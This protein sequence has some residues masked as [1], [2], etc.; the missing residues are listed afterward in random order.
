MKITDKKCFFVSFVVL[1]VVS[2]VI[3]MTVNNTDAYYDSD[4]Y[5]ELGQSMHYSVRWLG[6]GFRGYLLPFFFSVCYEFGMYCHSEFL[7]YRIFSSLVFAL[8][9]SCLFRYV[10]RM[11]E[12]KVSDKR[13]VTAGG[14]CGICLFLFFRG[15]L[16]YSLSDIYA[17]AL[18]LLSLIVLYTILE[19]RQKLWIQGI[20]ALL[21]GGGAVRSL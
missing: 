15:L 1:F 21:L 8:M 14:V 16:I 7:G 17:F 11:L 2:M 18:N 4:T 9:F 20:E 12:I 19:K 5:W 3:H 13:I 10:A 6:S